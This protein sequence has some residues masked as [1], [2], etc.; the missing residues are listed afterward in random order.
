MMEPACIKVPPIYDSHDEIRKRQATAL[1]D[2][3]DEKPLT[4]KQATEILGKSKDKYTR[5]A[6]KSL[7]KHG[8][9]IPDVIIPKAKKKQVRVTKPAMNDSLLRDADRTLDPPRIFGMPYVRSY[10]YKPGYTAFI[11]K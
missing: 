5:E 10:P 9:K 8:V 7:L 3:Y 4:L 11:L 1:W 6:I 2:A